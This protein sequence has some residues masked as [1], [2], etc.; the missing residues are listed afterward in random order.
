ML[1]RVTNTVKKKMLF[2]ELQ[3]NGNVVCDGLVV[4]L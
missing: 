3:S 1:T 2:T 4:T